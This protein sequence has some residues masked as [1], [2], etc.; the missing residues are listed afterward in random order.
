MD[1]VTFGSD[2][3]RLTMDEER[4]EKSRAVGGICATAKA[5]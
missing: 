3:R 2:R 4:E 1:H 5:A